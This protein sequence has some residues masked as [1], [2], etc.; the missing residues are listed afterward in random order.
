MATTFAISLINPIKKI[1]QR[2]NQKNKRKETAKIFQEIKSKERIN[3]YINI[4][5]I[6]QSCETLIAA[7][8]LHLLQV[9]LPYH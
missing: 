4:K 6:L 9:Y 5:L 1:L 2:K 3:I 8:F 7:I